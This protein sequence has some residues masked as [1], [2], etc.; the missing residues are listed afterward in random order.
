MPWSLRSVRSSVVWL[1]T[2]ALLFAIAGHTE[3]RRI[4]L[5][6]PRARVADELLPLARAV[7]GGEG[8][9][10]VD[11]GTGQLLLIGPPARVGEALAILEQQD[12]RLA[13]YEVHYES[14]TE[15]ELESA[16]ASV[17]WRA[18]GR[19]PRIGVLGNGVRVRGGRLRASGGIRAADRGESFSGMLRIEEGRTGEIATGSAFP[20]DLF[21]TGAFGYPRVETV[22]VET[23]RGFSVTARGVGEGRVE[24]SLAPIDER[25]L[26]NGAVERTAAATQVTVMP[27]ETVVFARA[28]TDSEH[29]G[30]RIGTATR[31]RA[32][33][34][35][36]ERVLLLRVE[37][38]D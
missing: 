17:V 34:D 10:V 6:E 28:A 31:Y 26:G 33:R 23:Q 5:Y 25:P 13:Q 18:G 19:G 11:S 3:E 1:A 16:G 20:V 7:L 2:G 21:G 29:R 12:R 27:G 30:S 14:R 9:A 15:A 37:R 22:Y 4:E 8:E 32:G 36:D 24:V 38:V 35:L